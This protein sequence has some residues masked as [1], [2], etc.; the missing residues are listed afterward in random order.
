MALFRISAFTVAFTLLNH[1]TTFAQTPDGPSGVFVIGDTKFV[2]GE[3]A[4]FNFP[5]ISGYTLRVPWGDMETLNSDTG[6]PAYDFSRIDT[7]LENARSLGKKVTFEIFVNK[8]P[9]YILSIP[10]VV[11]WTNPNPNQGGV[12]VVPWDSASLAAYKSMLNAMANHVV[13][14]TTWRI[15][16]HPS[17]QSVDAPIVGLQGLRELSNT[18]VKHPDYTRTR[19]VQAVLDSVTF[20]RTAFPTKYGFLA[21]FSMSDATATPAL[22]QSVYDTLM[23]NFNSDGKLSLGFFQETLSDTGPQA[24]TLG[25]FLAAGS[26]KTYNLLQALEP[27]TLQP[28]VVRPA[29]IASATPTTGLN[30]AWTNYGAIYTEIYGAD[31][32]NSAN[33][34]GLSQWNAFFNAVS[35]V[36]GNRNT[37]KLVQSAPGQ[38]RIQWLA[39]P[40]VKYRIYQSTDLKT[41]TDLLITNSGNGDV[42]LPAYSGT[43]S[44]YRVEV[45]PPGT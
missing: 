8:V 26:S 43:R 12:Q 31:V 14:N 10:G 41:W 5:F 34:A 25:K 6:L 36:R 37:P 17:L 9:T 4:K 3:V 19:F 30:F 2:S 22:D 35:G 39:D 23:A 13:A 15:A 45:C 38:M 21:L 24:T 27:W 28:G 1:A 16:D 32:L 42:A 18:L 33:T 29:E 11:T 7:T 44:F 40:L 20:S